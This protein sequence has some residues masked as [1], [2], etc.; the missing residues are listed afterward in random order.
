MGN[1]A[2]LAADPTG[3]AWYNP[4]TWFPNWDKAVDQELAIVKQ[5]NKMFGTRHVRLD[6]FT[7]EER[8]RI[9]TALGQKIDWEGGA[10]RASQ[11]ALETRDKVLVGSHIAL[12]VAEVSNDIALALT[13]SALA[14]AQAVSH[15][16]KVAEME[17]LSAE[18]AKNVEL[19]RVRSAQA[20]I[21]GTAAERATLRYLLTES[22]NALKAARNFLGR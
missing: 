19:L 1:A 22:R 17:R 13:V 6:G 4:F 12:K 10:I 18:A 16:Q 9:E 7:P 5:L 21:D 3:L 14:D 2:T 8:V 11:G 15:A 20:K